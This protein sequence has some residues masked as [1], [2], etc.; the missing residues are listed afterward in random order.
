MNRPPIQKPGSLQYEICQPCSSDSF[1]N[2]TNR[3]LV[4]QN[5]PIFVYNICYDHYKVKLKVTN[6][7]TLQSKIW[8]PCSSDSFENVP[9]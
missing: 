1:E 6:L 2:F 7:E 3:F 8:Q 9:N 4:E 5:I